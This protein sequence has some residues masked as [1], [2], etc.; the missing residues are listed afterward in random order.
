MRNTW[1]VFTERSEKV[2]TF[3]D[4]KENQLGTTHGRDSEPKILEDYHDGHQLLN[5]QSP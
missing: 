4:L 5:L 2:P 3:K 1:A